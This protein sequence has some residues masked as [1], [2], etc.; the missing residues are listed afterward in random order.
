MRQLNQNKQ[1]MYYANY[2]REIIVYAKD[3]EGN[4]LTQE[5]DGEVVEVVDS[6]ES[7]YTDPV[8]FK[9]NI[10]FNTGE[11]RMAEYG[12][13]TGDYNAIISAN[14]GELPFDEQTL[15]WH[16]SQPQF[17]S[18]KHVIPDSA[19]YRVKAIKTSLNE[20]RFLLIKRVDDNE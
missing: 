1:S 11:T 15:I 16:K 7:G 6:K 13:N 14:K 2:Q 19:D 5:I 12:L 18:D 10:S 3:S 9:A 8:Q 20:E 17:D 4:I